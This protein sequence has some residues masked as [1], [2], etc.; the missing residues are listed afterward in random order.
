VKCTGLMPELF[1]DAEA[2]VLNR[3]EAWPSG[4]HH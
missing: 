3:I 1:C 4:F 2:N